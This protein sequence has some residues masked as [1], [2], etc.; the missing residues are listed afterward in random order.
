MNFI[1]MSAG[2]TKGAILFDP[3]VPVTDVE[4]D[5]DLATAGYARTLD[6]WGKQ[7]LV[8]I[9]FA[10]ARGDIEGDVFEERTSVER[11]G[12]ADVRVRMSV[13]LL[14]P[15]AM[16]REEFAK[17]PRKTVLGVSM[18]VQPPTGQYDE[19][20]LIN[21]GTNRWAFKPE[22]GISVPV[23]HWFL[24]AYVGVWLIT[25]NDDFF[26]G[27][28]T[29]RQDP[30]T[31]AQAHAS[32]TFKSRAWIAFDATWYGGGSAT[33]DDGSPSERQS[34]TRL[35][36]TFSIPITPR[37]SIKV[38]GSTGASSRTGTDFDTYLVGWQFAWFDP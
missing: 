8:G 31:S 16:S 15:P 21:L 10:Y 2:N 23:G 33:V 19:T 1:V 26:P 20:K 13:N 14:G 24:D 28:A 37:Q 12:L 25:N 9:G 30:L 35:G 4:A 36:G 7:G 27:D 5:L 22:V 3:T 29:R 32:Y 11:S 17:A 6:L 38:A 18:T 34:N